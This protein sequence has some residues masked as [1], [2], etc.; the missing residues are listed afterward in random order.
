[1]DPKPPQTRKENLLMD[2]YESSNHTEWEHLHQAV[3]IHT[4][5]SAPDVMC[6]ASEVSGRS[7]LWPGGAEEKE[8]RARRVI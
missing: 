1:L 7:V 8:K 3:F 5:M 2:E 4:E 6:G